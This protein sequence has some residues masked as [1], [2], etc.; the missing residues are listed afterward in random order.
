MPFVEGLRCRECARAVPGR[1]A[2]RLR[3]LLRAARGRLRL[4]A[5]SPP[6]SPARRIAAGPADHLALRRPAAGRRRR[7]R[8]T[9]APGSRRWC[10]PTGWRPSWAWAS[11]GSRTTRSTPPARSR[12]GWCRSPSTK[13]RELGLQGRGLRLHRQPGQLGR[14][15][16]RPGRACSRSCSSPPTS[17]RARSSPPRS[18]AATSSPSRATTTTSTGCAPSWRASTRRGRSSTSTCAPTT[19]RAPRRWPSRWPS[20]WAG[21]RPTTWSCPI[22]SGSQL[23]KIAQ[24]LRGAAQGRAARRR[25]PRADLGRPGR[26]VLAGGHRVR[27]GHRPRHARCKP[28]DHRQVARHRQPGRRVL[29]PR[30]GA[31]ERRRH[32]LRSPTTRSSRASA[33]WPA[34]RGS[35]PRRP[36]ASPSPPW[37]SWPPRAW[38]GPT[39]GWSPTSPAT[40]SR[41]SRPWRRTCGPTATIAP[42]LDGLR[43]RPSTSR[44]T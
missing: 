33:C 10:G 27:R 17:R 11:C 43:R 18:T 16:R 1:G 40:G 36:A 21:R 32:R 12:T 19:P 25:A 44:T 24:G 42:T 41:P 22:A 29:R 28:D 3:V 35:S 31:V 15:P 2:A 9:W 37:P 7:R 8:S 39:S 20:S 14:R 30:G 34:P 13:A 4:R 38:C 26:R 6:P 23:T 5:P